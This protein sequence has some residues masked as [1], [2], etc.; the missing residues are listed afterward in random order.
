[1]SARIP[2]RWYRQPT[3]IAGLVLLAVIVF[4]CYGASLLT[5]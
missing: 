4:M 1:M 3:L 2:A 5:S